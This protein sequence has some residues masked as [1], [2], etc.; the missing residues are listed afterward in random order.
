MQTQEVNLEE[1]EIS[2]FAWYSK[3]EVHDDSLT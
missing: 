1:S 3:A 2:Q